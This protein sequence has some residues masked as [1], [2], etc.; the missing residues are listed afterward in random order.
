MPSSQGPS[1]ESFGLMAKRGNGDQLEIESLG[2]FSNPAPSSRWRRCS[3]VVFVLCTLG[4]FSFVVI[5]AHL[6][7][8]EKALFFKIVPALP[9][10]P[11]GS[12]A[13]PSIRRE[14]RSLNQT[15]QLQY[16]AA[17]QCLRDQPSQ[18][19]MNQTLYDDFPW[20]HSRIGNY[21][22]WLDLPPH[23]QNYDD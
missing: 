22:T 3:C 18:L 15:E 5:L 12:C 21:C 23:H 6:T 2:K 14:W 1:K 13:H 10:K 16:I 11:Q 9:G 8:I 19:G 20:I 7:A 4:L 17:V